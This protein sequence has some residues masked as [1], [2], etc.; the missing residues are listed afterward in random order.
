M[1]AHRL[2]SGGRYG[3]HQAAMDL[4]MSVVQAITAGVGAQLGLL[5]RGGMVAIEAAEAA[6]VA[7]QAGLM[8]AKEAAQA[9]EAAEMGQILGSKG[10]DLALIGVTTGGISGLGQAV[11]NEK[12]WEKGGLAGLEEVFEGT[13]RGALAGLA[14]SVAS[15]AVEGVPLGRTAAGGRETLGGLMG[16]LGADREA[17]LVAP[18]ILR[19][20]LKAVSSS[21]GAMAGKGVEV[22]WD[23]NA[24]RFRGSA[25]EEI[26]SAGKFAAFQGALEGAAETPAARV[27]A[28]RI[29]GRATRLRSQVEAA[30]TAEPP[31]PAIPQPPKTGPLPD[32]ARPPRPVPIPRPGLEQP[33]APLEPELPMP[34]R[35]RALAPGEEPVPEPQRRLGPPRTPGVPPDEEIT[36]VRPR[37]IAD[38]LPDQSVIQGPNPTISGRRTTSTA[39]P[40]SN[41][42]IARRH[43]TA[44]RRPASSSLFRARRR[45]PR[46]GEMRPASWK[47]R[48]PAVRPNAGR[49]SSKVRISGAGNWSR[50]ST[51]R[52]C[53]GA[54]SAC[55]P[56]CPAA[57]P[58][59][60]PA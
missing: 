4:G 18:A 17:G 7:E 59:T 32:M 23:I 47:R 19:T 39:T 3:W 55:P 11:F 50:T 33:V 45:S 28:E 37:D 26:L 2:I 48:S 14:T 51:Q 56:A 25:A 1:A 58:A 40:L 57:C 44:I 52:T 24:G 9:A 30:R 53:R 46:S 29:A 6:Q 60:S 38:E 5:S 8:T 22:G 20:T 15:Q 43:S 31:T 34:A 42:P 35:P 16:R 49:R 54:A 13:I 12:T 41:H 21:I 36:Q 27:H 10:A